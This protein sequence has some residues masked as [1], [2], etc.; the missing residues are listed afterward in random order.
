MSAFDRFSP[1]T[2]W[3]SAWASLMRMSRSA[4]FTSAS[5]WNPAVCSPI[6]CSF[7]NSAT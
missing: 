1:S 5:R 2:A 4:A 6:F 3:A 7:S